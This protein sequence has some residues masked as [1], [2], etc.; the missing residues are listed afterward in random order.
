MYV[1]IYKDKKKI[2]FV[3]LRFKK[4]YLK[5]EVGFRRTLF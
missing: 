1:D 2:I 3:Q 4:K 5:E